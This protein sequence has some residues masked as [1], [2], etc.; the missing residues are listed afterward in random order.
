MIESIYGKRIL[1]EMEDESS[2]NEDYIIPDTVE[3][4]TVKLAGKVVGIGEEV[5]NTSIGDIVVYGQYDFS[6]VSIEGVE[7][8]HTTEDNLICKLKEDE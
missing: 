6:K 8:I 4:D 5:I 7:Y 2:E 3:P 1:I